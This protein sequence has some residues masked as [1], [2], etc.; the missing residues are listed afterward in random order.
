MTSARKQ[1][2]S[3]KPHGEKVLYYD[4]AVQRVQEWNE[5]LKCTCYYGSGKACLIRVGAPSRG[6]G[7]SLNVSLA[8]VA[9]RKVT[10]RLGI[11]AG[12]SSSSGVPSRPPGLVPIARLAEKLAHPVSLPQ[13]E[14][15]SDN[16]DDDFEGG[17]PITKLHR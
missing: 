2:G 15:E 9:D 11:A 13:K 12:F 3:E 14:D 6:N 4:E 7:P 1:L 8:G 17:I 5:A 16:W 10:P